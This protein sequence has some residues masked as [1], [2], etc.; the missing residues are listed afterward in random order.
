ME[1]PS[2]PRQHQLETESRVQFEALLPPWMAYRSLDLDYGVD[3]EVELF[4]SSSG[5]VT[6]LKLNV[7]L[8]ATESTSS[9][10]VSI[11]ARSWEYYKLLEAPTLIVLWHAASSSLYARWAHSRDPH[12]GLGRDKKTT[13]RFSA[14]ELWTVDMPERLKRELTYYNMLRLPTLPLPLTVALQVQ[15]GGI[16]FGLLMSTFT[17]AISGIRNLL[18]PTTGQVGQAS[19]LIAF[20]A[21]RVT[22]SAGGVTSCTFHHRGLLNDAKAAEGLIWTSILGLAISLTSLGQMHVAA[23]LAAHVGLRGFVWQEPDM[24]A[25]FTAAFVSS[26]RVGDAI[27]LASGLAS[28]DDEAERA[29]ASII[30]TGLLVASD[31]MTPHEAGAYMELLKTHVRTSQD[32]TQR[33]GVLYTLASYQRNHGLLSSSLR[34]YRQAAVSDPGYW[35]RYYF[36]RDI[37]ALLFCGGRYE[38]STIYYRQ[39]LAL[40]QSESSVT[41]NELARLGCALADA[42]ALSG[43]YAQSLELYS[44]HFERASDAE[45][46]VKWRAVRTLSNDGAHDNQK[47]RINAGHKAADL[48]AL[49]GRSE[50]SRLKAALKLDRCCALAWFNLGVWSR[51]RGPQ[52]AYDSFFVAFAL[53]CHDVEAWANAVLLGIAHASNTVEVQ[54]LLWFGYQMN[55]AGAVEALE[56]LVAQQEPGFPGDDLLQLLGQVVSV[57]ESRP[58]RPPDLRM[59]GD[60]GAFTV[61]PGLG[62][63]EENTT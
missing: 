7:Q 38:A 10:L 59:I 9:P 23:A 24:V 43:R 53:E 44:K 49:H 50:H 2:R 58:Q 56:T 33:A 11:A 20:W 55:G 8:K 35:R 61:L 19:I 41:V 40:A 48:T 62:L 26:G 5:E 60:D 14:D 18:R 21:D 57:Y 51:V 27:D 12:P 16:G 15:G 46:A 39:A 30:S 47:R 13:F 31:S 28:S 34:S 63:S 54:A 52:Q 4:D 22:V 17:R 36:L 25:A 3:G 32:G 1:R 45:W 6:G 42:E 29:S 37:G